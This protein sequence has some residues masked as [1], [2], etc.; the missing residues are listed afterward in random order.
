VAPEF[1][2]AGEALAQRRIAEQDRT[3]AQLQEKLAWQSSNPSDGLTQL[4]KEQE[5][6][7]NKGC[8]L[9]WSLPA[10]VMVAQPAVVSRPSLFDER[11]SCPDLRRSVNSPVLGT[12]SG[13]VTAH[14]L[15]QSPSFAGAVPLRIAAP[16]VASDSLSRSPSLSHSKTPT[17]KTSYV[18]AVQ[19]LHAR[20]IPPTTCTMTPSSTFS[21]SRPYPLMSPQLGSMNAPNLHGSG[22][23]PVC[24]SA[25]PVTVAAPVFGGRAVAPVQGPS[26][27]L[28][29]CSLVPTGYAGRATFNLQPNALLLPSS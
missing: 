12:G 7:R 3:I 21:G 19:Q 23:A 6:S 22:V 9:P 27:P 2:N 28:L 5:C 18:P 13:A 29:R 10:P 14:L 20:V 24:F 25:A 11:R 26:S 15:P 4:L 8:Q 16:L 1:S 17:P